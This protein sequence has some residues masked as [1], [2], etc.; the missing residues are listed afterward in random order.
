MT[1][2]N[3]LPKVTFN[4]A[5]AGRELPLS[6]RKPNTTPL[7]HRAIRPYNWLEFRLKWL[8][9]FSKHLTCFYIEK[10][11]LRKLTSNKH[12][13][14][15][16]NYNCGANW[17]VSVAIIGNWRVIKSITCGR[18]YK[19]SYSTYKQLT[20]N[21]VHASVAEL[22]AYSTVNRHNQ[23]TK[24]GFWESS[25]LMKILLAIRKYILDT[26]IGLFC[27]LLL[28]MSELVRFNVPSDT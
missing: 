6:N 19:Y 5:A 24:V 16:T 27:S 1:Y 26:C 11:T 15:S 20:F 17:K 2:A 12:K 21:I 10:S 23:V 25:H 22:W 18:V 3:N 28:Q 7:C 8:R 13:K 4:S 14:K 9:D